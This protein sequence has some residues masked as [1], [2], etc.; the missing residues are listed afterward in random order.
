MDNERFLQYSL[1]SNLLE[2]INTLIEKLN[3]KDKQI[4]RDKLNIVL[5]KYEK[6]IFN[7][8]KQIVITYA[9]NGNFKEFIAE[10]IKINCYFIKKLIKVFQ[11][12]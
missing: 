9:Q 1:F 4:V 12:Q 7:L 11:I 3:D 2:T 6:V 10:N 8:N 5:D